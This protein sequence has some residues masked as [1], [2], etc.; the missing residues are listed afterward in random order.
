MSKLPRRNVQQ[1]KSSW[2]ARH[3]ATLLTTGVAVASALIAVPSAWVAVQQTRDAGAA[4]QDAKA[5]LEAVQILAKNSSAS[6]AEARA[7]TEGIREL[8]ESGSVSAEQLKAMSSEAARQRAIAERAATTTGEQLEVAKRTAAEQRR[9]ALVVENSLGWAKTGAGQKPEVSIKVVNLNPATAPRFWLTWEE[10]RVSAG[11]WSEN[12]PMCPSTEQPPVYRSVGGAPLG[13]TL[14]SGAPLSPAE[15][16]AFA[17]GE[18]SL[19]VLG[20]ICYR[21]AQ[22]L[23]RTKFC[24]IFGPQSWKPCDTGEGDIE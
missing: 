10:R 17:K 1:P 12:T 18:L 24:R 3:G 7:L 15:A 9:P 23:R 20:S 8:A 6:L 21:D 4:A 14:T 11:K 2:W 19:L 13:I 22:Q 16:A 5:K